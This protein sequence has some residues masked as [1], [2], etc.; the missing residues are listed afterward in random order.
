MEELKVLVPYILRGLSVTLE[1]T[2]VALSIGLFFGAILAILR[3]QRG[4]QLASGALFVLALFLQAVARFAVDFFV[5]A[6][7]VVGP[8]TPGQLA[9]G[10]VVLLTAVLLVRLQ[11]Q[12][13]VIPPE[14]AAE[15]P[16]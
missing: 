4:Q 5:E 15:A 13:P 11:R 1:V 7:A 6:P 9:S 3:A 10:A 8:L 16:A 2:G 14:P 12:A